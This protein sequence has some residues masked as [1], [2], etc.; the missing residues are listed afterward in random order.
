MSITSQ[1]SWEKMVKTHAQKHPLKFTGKRV[2]ISVC[3]LQREN[4]GVERLNDTPKVASAV[5]WAGGRRWAIWYLVQCCFSSA[6]KPISGVPP[7][8]SNVIKSLLRTPTGTAVSKAKWGPNRTADRALDQKSG[9]AS[10]VFSAAAGVVTLG[11][12][13]SGPYSLRRGLR[14]AVDPWMFRM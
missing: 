1:W 2:I 13:A 8:Y 6:L 9:S 5:S 7:F 4:W 12:T 14:S 10:S 3:H 11:N